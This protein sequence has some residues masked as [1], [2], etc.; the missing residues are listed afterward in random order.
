MARTTSI[1]RISKHYAP[2]LKIKGT[3][4]EIGLQHGQQA[5]EEID[6]NLCTYESFFKET[7]GLTW[8]EAKQRSTI[9]IP[10][11]E[12]LYPEILDEIQGIADGAGVHRDD[13]L[14][15]NV[16][17]EIALTNFDD[18]PDSTKEPPAIT[19]G[20]TALAQLSPDGSKLIVG[21]NWDWVQELGDGIIMMDITTED[22]TRMQFMNEA[23][24]VGKIGMNSHGVG[25]CNNALRAG[26]KATDRLPTHIMSRRLL[27]YAKSFDEAVQMLEEY[28]GACATNYV[29]GDSSGKFATVEVSPRGAP[30]IAPLSSSSS[31][32]GASASDNRNLTGSGPSFVA[33]TNHIISSPTSFSRGPIHDR[34]SA[35]SFDRLARISELTSI[36]IEKKVPLTIDSVIERLKDE[37]G[38][39]VGICRGRPKNATGMEDMTTLATIVME[40]DVLDGKS[41]GMVTIGRPCEENLQRI[42][43]VF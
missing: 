26:A 3:P 23:G 21:Q 6:S 16:R 25:L 24:L 13:I 14:A 7:A 28:G 36:D 27:Q 5:N 10:I 33:H 2:I 43:W 12:R 34:P 8:K 41:K 38:D 39:P 17:S 4:Y 40:F 20:C 11:L 35:N 42:D 30:V 37:Q 29:L 31:S 15:I 22:G 18:S 9:F 19:D 32:V 1:P